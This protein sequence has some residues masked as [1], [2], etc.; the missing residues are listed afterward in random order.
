[1]ENRISGVLTDQ[2]I[3]DIG[4]A[5]TTGVLSKLPFAILY[6]PSERN[7]KRVMGARRESL[8]RDVFDG[9]NM[10]AADMPQTFNIAEFEKDRNLE[11]NLKKVKDLIISSVMVKI[12][13]T[14]QQIRKELM[15]QTDVGYAMLKAIARTNTAVRETIKE[16]AEHNK[17]M[18]RRPSYSIEEIAKNGSVILN[19]TR[20]GSRFS[21]I[22]FSTLKLAAGPELTSGVKKPV[23]TVLPGSA[24]LLPDGY[25]QILV[26]NES[27]DVQG[28]FAVLL[29]K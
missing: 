19:N 25:T 9:V 6:E 1:M 18:G 4:T 27:A 3:I 17:E 20:P 21:N 29:K 2:D 11:V 8:V 22:G 7:Q 10:H 23:I 12:D 28:S 13:D 14:L 26:T 16:I 5:L 15:Q 24:V